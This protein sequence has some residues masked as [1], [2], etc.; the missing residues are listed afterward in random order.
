M[1]NKLRY[2]L[3]FNWNKD[4]KIVVYVT[5]SPKMHLNNY[6]YYLLLK[7]KKIISNE[8]GLGILR[9]SKIKVHPCKFH[10]T[11]VSTLFKI[12]RKIQVCAH[13]IH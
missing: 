3:I 5:A 9:T 7:F 6:D 11:S 8:N 2:Q 4:N 13:V 12:S 1:G 10:F